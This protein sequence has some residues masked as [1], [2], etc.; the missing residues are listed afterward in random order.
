MRNNVGPAV[1]AAAAPEASPP[2]LGVM[3]RALTPE[4]QQKM[5]QEGGVVVEQ[6]AG[7]AARAG[8]AK[9]DII[10]AINNK[11]VA[12]A[13]DLKRL[14]DSAG[15]RAAILIERD[16]ARRYVAVKFG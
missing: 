6:V 5:G 3:V 10:L 9:G 13:N 16:G 12:S 8:I 11:P 4:E 14:V 7:A 1:A 2:K 15:E